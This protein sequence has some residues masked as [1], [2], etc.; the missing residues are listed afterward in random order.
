MTHGDLGDKT[1]GPPRD[2]D[3]FS[4]RIH[5]PVLWL[6]LF[7]FLAWLT[8]N[9]YNYLLDAPE[10]YMF[11]SMLAS[12]SAAV[13]ASGFLF[14]GAR[15]RLINTIDTLVANGVLMATSAERSELIQ[16]IDA[17][18]RRFRFRDAILVTSAEL[19]LLIGGF[20]V[21]PIVL[22]QREGYSLNFLMSE[23]VWR[24]VVYAAPLAIAAVLA[25]ILIG[26]ALGQLSAYG[27][28]ETEAT[29]MGLGFEVHLTD[30]DGAGGM[31]E[32]RRF[33]ILQASLSI[34]PPTWFAAWFLLTSFPFFD[35]YLIWRPYFLLIFFL[36]VFY[37]TLSLY[38]PAHGVVNRINRRIETLRAS[39]GG[40]A[41]YG[42]DVQ[43]KWNVLGPK[44]FYGL[45]AAYAG[46]FFGGVIFAVANYKAG[47]Y[48]FKNIT[49]CGIFGFCM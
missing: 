48:S 37:M 20:V 44:F 1:S 7:V 34:I 41:E 21:S 22:L 2:G 9:L 11:D 28:V 16:R 36:S 35:G 32:L 24:L 8:Y 26:A 45:L 40:S 38:V 42:A 39:K 23:V 47:D 29:K 4:S 27:Q 17:L 43:R 49:D 18:A 19:A 14:I 10:R 13:L 30:P 3:T 12:G 15:G 33:L 6:L 46:L 5:R 25:G 31:R